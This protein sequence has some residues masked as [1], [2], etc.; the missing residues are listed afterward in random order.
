M[1]TRSAT[2][3]PFLVSTG[4]PLMPEPPMST[5][6]IF[7][8]ARFD[9]DADEPGRLGESAE[10]VG[11]V[12][13]GVL[14]VDGLACGEGERVAEDG[15]RL[16]AEAAEVHLDPPGVWVE[17]DRVRP[18]IQVCV[19]VQLGVDPAEEVQGSS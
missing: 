10:A 4:A 13:V 15:Q 16:V 1:R 17:A 2:R 11:A 6:R 5:P 12:L 7:R 14:G 18:R 19:A 8:G 9:L 3:T